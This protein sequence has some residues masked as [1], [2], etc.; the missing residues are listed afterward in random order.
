[1][2]DFFKVELYA[3]PSAGI[4]QMEFLTS[5]QVTQLLD[6]LCVI[7]EKNFKYI[8][9]SIQQ[10]E[11]KKQI[12][13]DLEFNGITTR[14]LFKILTRIAEPYWRSRLTEEDLTPVTPATNEQAEYW[15]GEWK[16]AL[17][18]VEDNFNNKSGS[19]S[20]LRESMDAWAKKPDPIKQRFFF[21]VPG[22]NGGQV[23][24]DAENQEEALK[25]FQET[26][27]S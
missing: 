23:G 16:K 9:K 11:I 17:E 22:D 10:S 13:Q 24:I 18:K 1:M 25:I 4:R 14:W 5:D 19:G 20:R 7:S 3:L 6:D 15:I 2:R 21:Q 27:G 8:P 26:F 12:I